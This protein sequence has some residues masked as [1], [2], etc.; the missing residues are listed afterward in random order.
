MHN[1][2][3]QYFSCAFLQI[4]PLGLSALTNVNNL[5]FLLLCKETQCHF[6]VFH[7]LCMD[8]R[9]FAVTTNGFL[10]KNLHK[11]YELYAIAEVVWEFLN[12]NA[13]DLKPLIAPPGEYLLLDLLPAVI[14]GISFR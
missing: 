12:F 2:N 10:R 3:Q 7:F 6:N 5:Y 1:A 4:A 13:Y 14:L 11:V 8:A 9:L